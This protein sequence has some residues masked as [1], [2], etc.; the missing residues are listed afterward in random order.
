M[1]DSWDIGADSPL[2][3]S[4]SRRVDRRA[5]FRLAGA[6]TRR[7]SRARRGAAGRGRRGRHH[8]A[9]RAAQGRLLAQRPHRHRV[10]L[11]AAGPGA[12]PAVGHRR[13]WR[14]SSA[15]CWAARRSCSAWWPAVAAAPT[16]RRPGV[17][18]GA[19]HT[20]GGPGQFLGTD[21]YNRFASNKPGFDAAWA[22]FAGGP[23]RRRGGRGGRARRPAR[24]AW[25]RAEVWGLTRNR[26]LRRHVRNDGR[27]PAHE[28][29]AAYVS[30]EPRLHLLRVD[31]EG[32]RRR[33]APRR[34]WWCSR[35]TAPASP[36]VADVQR[37]PLGLRRPTSWAPASSGRT[38]AG[39]SSAPSRAPR[40]RRPRP[41][42]GHR[43][44]PR[45][46]ARSVAASAPRRRCCTPRSTAS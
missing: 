21:F 3:A 30:V 6:T 39:R 33:R 46:P 40:R 4:P 2:L 18:I 14:S 22:Q 15:T 8:P 32:R 36:C 10:P 31:A 34:P 17:Y 12:A 27:R 1:T 38:G 29:P 37:R 26:S 44:A 35:C 13:R 45:G 28:A 16:S 7:R 25:G 42:P 43:R 24:L 11:A 20:H 23:H 19:T 9:A 41:H 5:R